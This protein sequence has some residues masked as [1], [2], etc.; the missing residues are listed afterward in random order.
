VDAWL[1]GDINGRQL[2]KMLGAMSF[3][4]TSTGV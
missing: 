1:E 3:F 2:N 4:Q